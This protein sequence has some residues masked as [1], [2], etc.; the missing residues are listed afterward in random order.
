MVSTVL[1][2]HLI[3]DAALF[4]PGD[5]PM[6]LAVGLHRAAKL[7]PLS[8]LV[9]RFLCPA[10]RIDELAR[11]LR[12]DDAIALG[13]VADTGV[14]GLPAALAR[15]DADPRLT[16][17]AV[18]IAVPGQ[19][20]LVSGVREVLAGLP[21][22]VRCYLEL[23]QVPDWQAGL[24]AVAAARQGA[25]LRTG[26]SGAKDFPTDAAVAAFIVSCVAV[27]MP[28]KCTAGLHRAVRYTDRR[29]RAR[30]HG[31]L[32]ITLAVCA[33]VRGDDPAPVLAGRHKSRIAA[34]VHGIDAETATRARALFAGF[35]SCSIGEP[36]GDLLA[37]RLLEGE[38]A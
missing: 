11:E 17:L 34:A 1:L 12:P 21:D 8:W 35:G 32:N 18:E 23:P 28:F 10:S 2:E 13:V 22:R 9:G 6:P 20:D 15:I 29:T 30:H 4:P 26:G 38:L 31:F 5:A 16:L 33:A 27:G 25:K 3:D 19:P 14:A 36:A 24:A 7:G 37:L